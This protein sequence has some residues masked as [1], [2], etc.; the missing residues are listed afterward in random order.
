MSDNTDTEQGLSIHR[1]EALT[2]GIY[3]VAMTLLVIDLKLPE[4]IGLQSSAEI[5]QALLNL[6]PKFLA[7]VISFGVLA[8]FWMG[9]HRAH[10]HVRR[11]N[12]QLVALNIAQLGFVSLMPFACSVSG[13]HAGLVAQIVYSSDLAMLAVFALLTTHYIYRHPELCSAPMT[14]AVHTSA[15]LRIGGLIAISVAAVIIQW[16]LPQFPGFGN[17][18]FALMSLVSPLSRRVE[19]NAKPMVAAAAAP[20]AAEQ[21]SSHA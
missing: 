19:R 20:A 2:D 1:S 13:E 15:S 18:A 12:G 8:M 6:T 7:W 17:S 4:H 11:A 14:P 5:S 10:R 21:A 3:A 16:A 9:H